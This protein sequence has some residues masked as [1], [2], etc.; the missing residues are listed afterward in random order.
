MA[1]GAH[2]SFRGSVSGTGSNLDVLIVGFRPHT[3]KLYNVTGNCSAVWLDSMA[4]ASMQKIVDSG[5]GTSD[6]SFVSSG[7]VTPLANGFRLGTDTDLNVSAEVVHYEAI[8]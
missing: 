2:R 4:D 8:G 6:T 1:S 7:G 3:V 5:S